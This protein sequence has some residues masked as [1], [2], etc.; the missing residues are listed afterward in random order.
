[1]HGTNWNCISALPCT[2]AKRIEQPEIG[3]DSFRNV[4]KKTYYLDERAVSVPAPC[5]IV[6]NLYFHCA[7]SSTCHRIMLIVNKE[8]NVVHYY[9]QYI[10]NADSLI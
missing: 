7:F 4:P 10:A 2:A 3:S 9:S 1:M 8:V 5:S 6:L